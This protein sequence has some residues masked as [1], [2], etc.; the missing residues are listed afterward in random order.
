MPQSNGRLAIALL[1]VT[2]GAALAWVFR[3]PETADA[4]AAQRAS[5]GI[6]YRET[7]PPTPNPVTAPI[8]TANLAV[9]GMFGSAETHSAGQPDAAPQRTFAAS[10]ADGLINL[11]PREPGSESVPHTAR[12]VPIES[13]S[14]DRPVLPANPP[15]PPDMSGYSG[16]A[17]KHKLVDG[18]SLA[19]LAARYLGDAS[20]ASEI[21]ELNRDRLPAADV[22]PLGVTIDI[23]ASR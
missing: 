5:S 18:D 21:Y 7:P 3:Q 16:P 17:R 12:R 19:T 1:V 20:R 22:L 2:A 11:V 6:V 4:D 23:P 15:R 9:P 14:F 8:P 10:S 13:G